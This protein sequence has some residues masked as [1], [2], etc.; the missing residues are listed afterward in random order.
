MNQFFTYKFRFLFLVLHLVGL[1][2][3]AQKPT[4]SKN[5]MMV[6]TYKVKSQ[7]ETLSDPKKVDI[8]V[9]YMDGMGRSSQSIAQQERIM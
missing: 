7:D 9:T 5:Y 6:K 8:G 3:L 2:A 4:A 1:S